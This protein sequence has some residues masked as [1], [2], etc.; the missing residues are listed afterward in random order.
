VET[1]LTW[2]PETRSL[3]SQVASS[4]LRADFFFFL[5]FF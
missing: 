1:R 4:S 3:S 2:T 5:Q